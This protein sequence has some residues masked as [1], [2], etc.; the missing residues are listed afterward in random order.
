MTSGVVAGGGGGQSP[1]SDNFLGARKS[2][3][4]I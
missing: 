2:K 3:K 1:P 4:G